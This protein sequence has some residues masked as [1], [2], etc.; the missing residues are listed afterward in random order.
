MD[1]MQDPYGRHID[2]LRISVTDRCNLRCI[3][4]MPSKGVLPFA[5]KNILTYEEIV[6]VVR[7]AA[8]LGV[9]KIRITGGEPLMRKD[10]Q[11]LIESLSRIEGIEDISLT[12]NGT[13]LKRLAPSLAE[14]GLKRVNVSLDSLDPVKY[15]K[16]RRKG[17]LFD[18]LDG[19]Q[20]ADQAGLRPVKINMVVIR[21]VNDDEIE[22]FARL[23]LNNPYHVRFIEIMPFGSG[24]FWRDDKCIPVHEMM[25]RIQAVSPLEPVDTSW[26][27]PAEYFRLE[28]A[29]SLVGFISPMTRHFCTTCNR[30]RLTS[31]GK[32]RPCL[33]SNREIDVKSALRR[34]A[35]D[36][37]IARLLKL[38][39]Q[40][41]PEGHAMDSG[42]SSDHLKSMSQIGG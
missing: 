6:R 40:W 21:G 3:Y 24:G 32:L 38:S 12:T 2:Y 26:P 30:L 27:G 10:L 14:A 29:R 36:R 20:A 28:G 31:D 4:C 17:E 8:G 41:K 16:I 39:I 37:E 33:F 42:E 25:G 9:R 5:S 22:A 34:Q 15:G 7:L 1:S 11:R 18:V 23:T 13:L 35:S 19:I